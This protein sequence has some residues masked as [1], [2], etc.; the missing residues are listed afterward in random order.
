MN[1]LATTPAPL[2]QAAAEIVRQ[3]AGGYDPAPVPASVR[4]E[5]RRKLPAMEAQLVPADARAWQAWLRPLVG[6]VRN[7]PQPEAL[8]V[9]A[10]TCAAALSDI[11]ASL[12]TGNA[13]REACRRFAFWP[14]VADLDEWLQPDATAARL[15]VRTLRRIASAEVKHIPAQPEPKADP[16]AMAEFAR[17]FAPTSSRPARATVRPVPPETLAAHYEALADRHASA[18]NL[19]RAAAL[20][21][22]AAKLRGVEA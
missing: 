9:F 19:E 5:A 18:G 7:P 11:P 2:S 21:E 16:K 1:T 6:A 3:W 14:A 10:A 22:R 4:D 17:T 13:Q 15:E 20:F 12:L 8:S